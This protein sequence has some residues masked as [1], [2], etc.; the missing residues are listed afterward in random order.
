M[1]AL[2]V[3]LALWARRLDQLVS[4]PHID[5]P[6]TGVVVAI[7]GVAL[8]AWAMW[9]LLIE[10]GGLPA[11]AFPPPRL[12]TGGPYALIP[13]PIYVG[14]VGV[15]AGAA[16]ALGSSAGVWIIAPVLAAAS[17]AWVIGHERALT[18][19]LFGRLP[20]PRL[21]LPDSTAE[22]PS[23]W[24]RASSYVLVLLPWAG[25][26]WTI[27]SVQADRGFGTGG[28][29]GLTAFAAYAFVCAAPLVAPTRAAL[30]AFALDGLAAVAVM[31]AIVLLLGVRPLGAVV[32][33]LIAARPYGAR[34]QRMRLLLQ[35]AGAA[36]AAGS[37]ALG[38]HH[39]AGAVAGVAVYFMVVNRDRLWRAALG[40]A[41]RI[42]NSWREWTIAGGRIRVLNHGIYAGVGTAMGV[43][44]QVVLI[45]DDPALLLWVV[46][47]VAGAVVGAG[48]WA[49]LVEGSPQLLRPY[50][51]YGGILGVAIV[52]F[53][54]SASAADPWLLITSFGI[55]TTVTYAW[56]RLRC[57]VQGCC[58][59]SPAPRDAGIV[60]T[61]PQSR[62]VRLSPFAGLPVHATPLY[63]LCWS[64]LLG[65]VLWRL[66]RIGAP[67]SLI[68]GAYFIL[69]GVCR[70]VEEHFR[71]E[72]QTRVV[73][74]LRLYQWLA[75]G[76]IVAGAALSAIE[77]RAAPALV[78]FGPRAVP[79]LLV[80]GVLTF[81]AY[82][83]DF[84]RSSKRFSRLT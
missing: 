64:L 73:G 62:V 51:Y 48:L 38:R 7:A 32:G 3:A 55:G 57:L 49:Q 1:I 19:S 74:G 81:V 5:A 78:G 14:A 31:G 26:Q 60:Y 33:L 52:T 17:V 39:I 59:G 40:V 27:D 2:P 41:E 37:M 12:A 66:W 25:L 46:A 21:R 53:L 50:G 20:V 54:A 13:H 61:H 29:A 10:A 69:A 47:L 82:G 23:V 4:L 77:T 35:L 15:A 45:G 22:T 28:V 43:A 75:I 8:M 9:T 76:S 36:M 30:R 63:S 6:V 80:V 65:L 24:N 56:G 44:V 34:V 71:G 16:L 58:H 84:P 68:A 67:L 11:S 79:V 18:R 72:P 70:F 83:V 42:A